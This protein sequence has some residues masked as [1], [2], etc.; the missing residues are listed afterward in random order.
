MK[1]RNKKTGKIY[2]GYL[3]DLALEKHYGSLA[4]L[5]TEWEDYEDGHRVYY[6]TYTGDVCDILSEVIHP[7]ISLKMKQVGNYFETKE[8]AKQ[9]VEKL[10]AWTRLKDKGFKFVDFSEGDIKFKLG[11]EYSEFI[12]DGYDEGLEFYIDGDVQKDLE[13]LFGGEE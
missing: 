2:E 12:Y 6:I 9:A 7:E 11:K 5:N 4:E 13:L 8:E 3:A 10:K 1:V